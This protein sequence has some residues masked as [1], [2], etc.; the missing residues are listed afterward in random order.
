MLLQDSCTI[1]GQLEVVGR[2]A[3]AEVYR[4][5]D[6]NVICYKG[7]EGINYAWAGQRPADPIAFIAV[8]D[9]AYLPGNMSL[10]VPPTDAVET[11]VALKREFLRKPVL[12]IT[13][14]TNLSSVFRIELRESEAVGKNICEFGLW[15]V[16]GVLFADRKSIPVSKIQGMILTITWTILF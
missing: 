7:R 3:G 11:N 2:V 13:H 15:T 1:R 14:T 12:P 9:G 10:T 4:F 5:E 6:H 8:G 16:G